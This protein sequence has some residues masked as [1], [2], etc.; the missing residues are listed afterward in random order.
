MWVEIAVDRVSD[1]NVVS[2]VVRPLWVEITD[3]MA[4]RSV[5]IVEGRETLVG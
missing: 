3:I 4:S 2:R 1:P 5:D